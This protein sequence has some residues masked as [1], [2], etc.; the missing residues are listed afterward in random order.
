MF[1][2]GPPRSRF[3]VAE[4]KLR[5]KVSDLTLLPSVNLS[6]SLTLFLD[7]IRRYRNKDVNLQ[8]RYL[9]VHTPR[10]P[11]PLVNQARYPRL[12][13]PWLRNPYHPK[14]VILHI[15]FVS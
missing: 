15:K 3:P 9:Y 13:S 7:I 11:L 12:L 14:A 1:K 10:V 6:L 8:N 4:A 2:L 5:F